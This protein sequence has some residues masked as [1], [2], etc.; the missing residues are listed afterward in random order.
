MGWWQ[1]YPR[2]AKAGLVLIGG[3][4]TIVATM[5]FVQDFINYKS[6]DTA[7]ATAIAISGSPT[8]GAERDSNCSS[9]GCSI[10]A[11]SNSHC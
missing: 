6:S 11:P 7:Q 8:G 10:R 1:S 9:W 4:G 5:S 2:L 3:V